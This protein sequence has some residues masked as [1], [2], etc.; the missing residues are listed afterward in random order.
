MI[1]YIDLYHS[2][3]VTTHLHSLPFTSSVAGVGLDYGHDDLT[4]IVQFGH[5]CMHKCKYI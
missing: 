1:L 2:S 4:E 3:T 5:M